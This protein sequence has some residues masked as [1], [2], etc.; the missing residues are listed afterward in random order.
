MAMVASFTAFS[1]ASCE[2]WS[3]VT[4]FWSL[5]I[6]FC[7][8]RVGASWSAWAALAAASV[9]W[10][11]VRSDWRAAARW[12]SCRTCSSRWARATSAAS[13]CA[14]AYSCWPR[15]DAAASSSFLAV[16]S[17]A[18]FQ[19]VRVTNAFTVSAAQTRLRN[20]TKKTRILPST[21][22]AASSPGPPADS[23]GSPLPLR[24]RG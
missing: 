18:V 12:A 9:C 13:F 23:I 24:E 15:A 3:S 7:S 21:V 1:S 17:R 14:L 11:A 4:W 8:A 10:A 20:S 6:S 19:F 16:A 22:I 5:A 2:F